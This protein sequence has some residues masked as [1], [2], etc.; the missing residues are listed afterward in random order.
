VQVKAVRAGGGGVAAGGRPILGFSP[1]PAAL[2]PPALV[3]IRGEAESAD[4]EPGNRLPDRGTPESALWEPLYK[5]LDTWDT[6]MINRWIGPQGWISPTGQP[7]QGTDA[8]A[9]NGQPAGGPPPAGGT[10][11]EQ[12]TT[13]S[14][15]WRSPAA[16]AAGATVASTLGVALFSL[17]RRWAP[18]TPQQEKP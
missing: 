12:S 13:S 1:T 7:T 3:L 8:D 14:F 16:I 9:M 6:Q 5:A 18:A 2:I 11:P 17:R 15:S 4:A 10:P